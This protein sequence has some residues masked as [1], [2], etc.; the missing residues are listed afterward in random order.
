MDSVRRTGRVDA[1][2]EGGGTGRTVGVIDRRS[3]VGSEGVE[4]VVEELLQVTL[5]N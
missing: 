3:G 5:P 4:V 2:R 1:D